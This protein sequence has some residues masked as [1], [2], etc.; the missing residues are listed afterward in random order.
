M[1]PVHKC[2]VS[3]ACF[4]MLLCWGLCYVLVWLNV[5]DDSR[6]IEE[7]EV[8]GKIRR[9]A[10]SKYVLTEDVTQDTLLPRYEWII[11]L[12]KGLGCHAFAFSFVL[13]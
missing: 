3:C 12:G 9:V 2:G 5:P 1:S 7:V 13:I 10:R 11:M 8:V 6:S 4:G